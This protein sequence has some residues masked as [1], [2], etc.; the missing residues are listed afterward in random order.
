MQI[1][2]IHK[3]V[4]LFSTNYKTLPKFTQNGKNIGMLPD[5]LD[6]IQLCS[7]TTNNPGIFHPGIFHKMVPDV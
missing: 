1:V 5:F 2:Y 6:C 3:G 7:L 4:L